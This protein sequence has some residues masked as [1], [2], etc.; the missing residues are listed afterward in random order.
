MRLLIGYG[1]T[2]RRD[3]GVGRSIVDRLTPLYAGTDVSCITTPQLLPEV[4]ALVA[5]AQRVVFVDASI[6]GQAGT[7]RVDEV[8]PLDYLEEAHAFT[9]PGILYL[10]NL[11]YL[12]SPP[13]HLVTVTG[14]DFDLGETL[15]EAVEAAIPQAITE[16]RRLLTT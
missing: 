8:R 11:L 14:A 9:A 6:E 1:N 2:L 5:Q 13:A 4:A 3:D 16:I 12:A 15:S 10:A 7:V